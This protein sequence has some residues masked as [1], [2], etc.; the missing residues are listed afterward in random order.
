MK[1]ESRIFPLKGVIQNYVWGGNKYIP[2]LLGTAETEEP[3][4]EYWLGAHPKAPSELKIGEQN[5]LLDE[6]MTMN[7]IDALGEEIH[8]KFANL[9]FLFKVLDVRE[10][11]S[12]Q[13]HPTK[14][15]AEKGFKAENEK[16]IALTAFERNYKDENHKPEIMVALSEFYL[17]HGFLQKDKLTEVLKDTPEFTHLLPVFRDKGYFGLYKMVMEMPVRDSNKILQPLIDRLMPLYKSGKLAK[18]DPGYWAAK[19]VD[20]SNDTPN[21]DKGIYSIYFFNLVK[22]AKGEAVFQDAGIP[23]AYLEG[24]NIELMANSDNVLRG[25]LTPKHIDVPELLKHVVFDE[26]KPNI[27]LGDLQ[28]DGLERIYKSP[29]PDFQLS[30]IIVKNNDLYES[31]SKTAQIFLVIEGEVS[32][33]EGNNSLNV[34][35]GH[36]VFVSANSEYTIS[37]NSKGVIYKATAP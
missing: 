9:P 5:V 19:A 23:H 18:E 8:S 3:C 17:L 33:T 30:Q 35:S 11:L 2:E 20:A 14:K 7:L 26:V 6:Y 32:F 25:G 13:V 12:I 37:S 31:T 1:N 28:E 34:K 27:M 15:E 4:A 22:V 29:A 10:M 36:S 24:Q 21:L 16:G